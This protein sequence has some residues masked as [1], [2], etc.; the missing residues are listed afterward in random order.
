MLITFGT[1]EINLFITRG[2]DAEVDGDVLVC[3]HN[4]SLSR[5]WFLL[6]VGL[7]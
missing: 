1:Q 7:L 6:T 5:Q 2:L 4:V 3:I